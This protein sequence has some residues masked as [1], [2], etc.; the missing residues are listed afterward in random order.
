MSL[1]VKRYRYRLYPTET[2]KV[3]LA[4]SFGAA[5]Y[6]YNHGREVIQT[7]REQGQT[8]FVS[9]IVADLPRLKRGKE[10]SWLSDVSAVLLQQSLRHLQSAL[11][12]AF[13]PA[14][15]Q[16]FPTKKRKHD[17]QSFTLTRNA[18]TLRGEDLLLAKCDVP[19]RV[20]W[21]RPLPSTPSSLTIIKDRQGGYFVSFV[22]EVNVSVLPAMDSAVGVD[23]GI[24]EFAVLNDGENVQHIPNP[25]HLEVSEKRLKRLQRLYSRKYEYAKQRGKTVEI[26]GRNRVAQSRTMC[27]IQDRIRQLHGRIRQQR[28]DF[29]R[30]SARKIVHENQVIVLEDLNVKGMLKNRRLAKSIQSV[31]WGM[32]RRYVEEYARSWERIVVRVGRFF[33][34]SQICRHCHYRNRNLGPKKH[35]I[36]PSCHREHDRDENASANIREEGIRILAAG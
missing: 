31:G 24:R 33:P 16:R 34:S 11:Q 25:R 13:D 29:L 32:F 26:H 23:L 10:T 19:F 5:R 15:N 14:Q 4:R 27:R 18:F 35:W 30:Q 21:T 20:V 17:A 9:E 3:F 1:Q 12:K 36:C 6:I 8:R 2:Q 7:A 22:V 28:E